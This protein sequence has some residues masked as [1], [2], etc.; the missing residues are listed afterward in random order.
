MTEG[1]F[2]RDFEKRI[3]HEIHYF[4]VRFGFS[5]L[6]NRPCGNGYRLLQCLRDGSVLL[7]YLRPRNGLRYLHSCQNEHR[8]S[9][10]SHLHQPHTVQCQPQCRTRSQQNC[11]HAEDCRRGYCA[12]NW[13][14]IFPTAQQLW[15]IFWR[16]ALRSARSICRFGYRHCHLLIDNVRWRHTMDSLKNRRPLLILFAF[17]AY[18][19]SNSSENL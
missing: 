14:R 1:V 2:P 15:T 11:N 12:P 10:L 17:S 3:I 19:A 5:G 8:I 9:R 13:R 18:A 6:N 7:R 16:G 4:S